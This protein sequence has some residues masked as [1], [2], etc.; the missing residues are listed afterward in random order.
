MSGPQDSFST[1]QMLELK[2]TKK[3]KEKFNLTTILKIAK[4]PKNTLKLD[5]IISKNK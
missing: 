3:I 1:P 2:V 4:K 5:K